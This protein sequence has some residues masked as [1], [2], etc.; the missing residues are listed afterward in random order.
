MKPVIT[1]TIAN[2]K[3][4]GRKYAFDGRR[5]CLIGRGEG[6]DIQLPSEGE[7]LSVSRRHCL[8]RIDPP[9][10]Y[11]RDDGSYNGTFINGMQIGRPA[12]WHLPSKATKS[13]FYDYKLRPG[14][15][16]KIGETIFEVSLRD[17]KDEGS[18]S[19]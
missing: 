11:V 16:L 2:G 9:D 12:A 3:Y 8:L 7:F 19:S 4:A 14:D 5:A 13:P 1:L 15:Q 6:C 17:E 18:V 10:L